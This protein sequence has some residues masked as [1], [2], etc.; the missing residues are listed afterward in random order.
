VLPDKVSKKRWL[1]AQEQ[2]RKGIESAE[3]MREWLRVRR[4]T[5]A[6]LLD[7]LKGEISFDSSKRIL[8]LGGGPTSIFLALREG[9]KYMV[10]PNCE[11]LFRLHPFMREVEE[12]KDV[13]FI[14]SPIEEAALDKQFDL[15]FSINALDHVGELKPVIDKID[16][17]L[18]G[19]LVIIVD[20]YADRVVRDVI[21]F[22]DVDLPHP[23][24]FVAEDIIKL[25]SSYRLIK[26][27]NRIYN[28]F[29][30]CTFKGRKEEIEIYRIDKFI[31]RIKQ[32]LS[33]SG[34]GGIIFASKYILCYSL[35][36]LVASLRRRERPIHPLKKPR[37]FLFRKRSSSQLGH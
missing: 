17:L 36:L 23:H 31:S 25:F 8:E 3:D 29:S 14:A 27:D 18:A 20:C 35:A 1:L 10:D 7:A 26:Q 11:L 21:S 5:W 22:F 15:I 13:N 28:I 12:Y 2:E 4:Y 24:H 34:R 16:E 6:R 9:G 30:E 33:S 37:L 19:T 32:H